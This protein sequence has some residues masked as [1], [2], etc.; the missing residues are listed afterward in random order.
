MTTNQ[1]IQ[2]LQSLQTPEQLCDFYITLY[3]EEEPELNRDTCIQSF[4]YGLEGI[5]YL[6]CELFNGPET[7][8]IPLS[9]HNIYDSINFIGYLLYLYEDFDYV[10]QF[11][12]E[13]TEWG[14]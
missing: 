9:L 3:S 12:I 10:I 7:L 2:T 5:E 11:I 4:N 6:E 13:N 1:K 8:S 14:D